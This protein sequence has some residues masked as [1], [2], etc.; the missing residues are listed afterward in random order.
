[1]LCLLPAANV[2]FFF[3]LKLT[4]AT[5]SLYEAGSLD[6]RDLI[7]ET[8]LIL[9]LKQ[10]NGPLWLKSFFNCIFYLW[11]PK[12]IN[13]TCVLSISALK[14][15]PVQVFSFLE[16]LAKYNMWQLTYNNIRVF[17]NLSFECCRPYRNSVYLAGFTDNSFAKLQSCHR[18]A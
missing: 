5:K 10:R 14:K 7:F 2:F 16:P 4:T 6:A 3:S 1:M 17:P 15:Q 8:E 12:I 13:F 11:N 9:P 18:T